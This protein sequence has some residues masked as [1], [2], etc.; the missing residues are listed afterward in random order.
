MN[1]FMSILGTFALNINSM[2]RN[3]DC[4][5]KKIEILTEHFR[6]KRRSR[7]NI[8]TPTDPEAKQEKGIKACDFETTAPLMRLEPLIIGIQES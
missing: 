5:Q 8:K 4:K 2:A 3:E 7:N 6:Q 1:Q